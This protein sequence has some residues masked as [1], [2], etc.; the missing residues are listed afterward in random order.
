[1][2]AAEPDRLSRRAFGKLGSNG[3]VSVQDCEVLRA[4]GFEQ[5]SFRV[6]VAL[7]GVMTV[8]VI[9]RHVEARGDFC[10]ETFD[11]LQLEAG[12]LQ[13][14]PLTEPRRLDHRSRRRT[15]VAS[16][17]ASDSRFPKNVPCERC[18]GRL[19]IRAGDANVLAGEKRR[20]Q[21]EFSDHGNAARADVLEQIQ[22]RGNPRR[23]YYQ[24]RLLE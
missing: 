3:I 14:V 16:Y 19:S 13:H 7:E 5:S 22:V 9:L 8:Q 17:L 24:F 20:G 11:R 23:D 18:R 4:L 2:G 6:H 15:D 21:L 10:S 1:M 12:K